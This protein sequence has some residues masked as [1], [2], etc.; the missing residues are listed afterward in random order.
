MPF[1]ALRLA[2]PL[3]RALADQG[4]ETPTPIQA[5]AIPPALEGRDILGCAQTGTGKTAA[6]ALPILHGLL[7]DRPKRTGRGTPPARALILS[8]TRELATQIG[9]SFKTYGKH[10][11]LRHTVIFGGVGQRPQEQALRRGIDVIVAT[12]GRLIDLM[13]Q[14]LVN[15]RGI[16]FLVLDEADRMLDMGFINRRSQDP[17]AGLPRSARRCCSPRRCPMRSGVSPTPVLHR[18]GASF[19]V[20]GP[21]ASTVRI[22]S[23]RPSISSP[24]KTSRFCCE[25]L[26]RRRD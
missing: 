19:P 23:N 21:V 16:E 14:G 2:P 6:F 20:T 12:P 15:F 25:R 7:G 3:V 1:S 11:K 13:E 9:D 17:R 4:Y 24:E 18:S 8:P 22:R 26:L 10:T 5:K